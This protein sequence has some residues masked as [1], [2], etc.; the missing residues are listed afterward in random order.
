MRPDFADLDDRQGRL[1]AQRGKGGTP[2]ATAK[3]RPR[4]GRD[5][6][7]RSARWLGLLVLLSLAA[8]SFAEPVARQAIAYNTA[9]ETAANTL[10][11]RNVLRARDNAP[12]HFTSIPQIRGSLS[13]GLA[14]P[15]AF[16][17]AG[18]MA[19]NGAGLGLQ[20]LTSPSFDVAALD[21]QDFTRGLLEPLPPQ[22]FRYFAERGVSEQL[23]A[24]LLLESVDDETNGQRIPNDPRCWFERPDCPQQIDPAAI[25]RAFLTT[26]G[27][28]RYFFYLYTALTPIG[29]PLSPAAASDPALLTVMEERHLRLLPT[30]N[31]QYQLYHAEPREAV[32]RRST[33][34]HEDRRGQGCVAREVIVPLRPG[35]GQRP[36]SLEPLGVQVQMRSVA[37][38][39]RFLG[40][41]VRVQEEIVLGPGERQRCLA[42]PAQRGIAG[43]PP[44]EACLF[45]V[46]RD[47]QDEIPAGV[48][49][50]VDYDDARWRVPRYAEPVPGRRG[51]YT[52]QVM[53]LLT[54]LLNLQKASSAI[55]T[56]RAVQLVR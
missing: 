50:T 34:R 9:V 5:A 27:A 28:G 15:G 6:F 24:L 32:C 13:V 10:L 43:G 11:I 42:F 19:Q 18:P 44:L 20:A 8:C 3:A 45:H 17:P 37:E 35:G 23:L 2:H 38:I 7:A 26:T 51:D 30:G 52:L 54:E 40:L 39:F 25:E 29:P 48:A 14:Q 22:L 4:H 21:T 31:G 1:P 41:V 55:P 47:P 33:L 12:L 56:T 46:T 49:F 53:S 16:G 36:A